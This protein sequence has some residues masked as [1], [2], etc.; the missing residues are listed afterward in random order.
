MHEFV[1]HIRA[2]RF[3]TA[4]EQRY[5]GPADNVILN[6]YKNPLKPS[7]ST[8]L[9]IEAAPGLT[10]WKMVNGRYS[11]IIGK[12]AAFV[13]TITHECADALNQGKTVTTKSIEALILA[14]EWNL[15]RHEYPYL[16]MIVKMVRKQLAGY[17]AFFEEH[18]PT[19]YA[20]EMMLWHPDIP[21]AG[22]ADLLLGWY[23]KRQNKEVYMLADLKTGAEQD[24]HFYQ[25]MAYAVL[26]EAIFDIEISMLGVL[27]CTGKWRKKPNF[28]MKA[29]EIRNKAGEK[30]ETGKSLF[31]KCQNRYEVWADNLTSEQPAPPPVIPSTFKLNLTPKDHESE[32]QAP[33]AIKAA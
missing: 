2:K 21:W 12:T 14:D 8:F 30:N 29:K 27:H 19:I 31:R 20:T 6:S 16:S 33:F 10:N 1:P 32:N 24:K 7:V 22:T 13:G 4:S 15:W 11:N 17:L 5:Y 28:K 23:S 26:A 25:V 9:S 18:R 3:V